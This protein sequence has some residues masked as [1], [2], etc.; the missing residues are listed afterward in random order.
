MILVPTPIHKPVP[1]TGSFSDYKK[2]MESKKQPSVVMTFSDN[3]YSSIST[4]LMADDE[5][6]VSTTLMSFDSDMLTLKCSLPNFVAYST[7]LNSI[8]EYDYCP[9]IVVV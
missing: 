7:L 4:N 2:D 6:P 9:L 3:L 5:N 8:E 1:H